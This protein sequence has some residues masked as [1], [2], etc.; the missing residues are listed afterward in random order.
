MPAETM[1]ADWE[2]EIAA[3]APVIDAA[4][5][6]LIDLRRQP[7]RV[8]EISELSHLPA[9]RDLLLHLNGAGSGFFT[10]KCDVWNPGEVDADELDA[11][12]DS[13]SC[14]LACYVDLLPIENNNWRTPEAAAAWARRMCACFAEAPLR[15]CRVDLVIRR[16]FFSAKETG[17]GA[18]CYVIGCESSEARATE[19]LSR[20]LSAFS[21]AAAALAIV[22]SADIKLQ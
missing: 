7:E 10:S 14:A 9:L 6:G 12:R 2:F 18:T 1:E 22:D 3:D 21:N 11:D 13:A 15:N 8:A 16:A 20:A 19:S 5:P 17:I 4:W